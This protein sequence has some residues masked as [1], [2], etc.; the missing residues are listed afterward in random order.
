MTLSIKSTIKNIK[1]NIP[2]IYLALK[3]SRTPLYGKLFG[4]FTVAYALSPIDL[5]PDFIPVLGYLDDLILVPVFIFITLKLI[6]DYIVDE[7]KEEANSV[8]CKGKPKKW[9]YGVPIVV[10]WIILGILIG[11]KYF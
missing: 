5:I 7:Y 2:I 9:Y 1:K 3:D 4:M 6:P 8:W 10:T 11:Y